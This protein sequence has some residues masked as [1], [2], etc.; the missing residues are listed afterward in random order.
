MYRQQG[1]TEESIWALCK[2]LEIHP[3]AP[4]TTM[5]LAEMLARQGKQAEAIGLLDAPSG[6]RFT[7]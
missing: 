3:D 1:K 6:S 4:D 5:I 2:S 7:M